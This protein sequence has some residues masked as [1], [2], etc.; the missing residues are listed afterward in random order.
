LISASATNYSS[1]DVCGF[2]C[3]SNYITTFSV[4]NCAGSANSFKAC[5]AK[6]TAAS[7]KND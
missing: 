2:S 6:F 5:R 4:G 7:F 3:E 1:I